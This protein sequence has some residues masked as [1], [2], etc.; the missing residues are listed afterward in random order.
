VL[1]E[2]PNQ[3]A[4]SRL[5][6]RQGLSASVYPL[7]IGLNAYRMLDDRMLEAV[8]VLDLRVYKV[9]GTDPRAWLY[10]QN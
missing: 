8:A 2:I 7:L 1:A 6:Q 9:R 10:P 5:L 4:L 3:P